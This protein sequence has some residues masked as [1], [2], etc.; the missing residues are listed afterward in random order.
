MSLKAH[1]IHEVVVLI[2]KDKIDIALREDYVEFSKLLLGGIDISPHVFV[3]PDSVARGDPMA[4]MQDMLYFCSA[5]AVAVDVFRLL[6]FN[7][8]SES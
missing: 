2:L 1:S 3:C 8:N 7:S 6:L 4:T 5:N